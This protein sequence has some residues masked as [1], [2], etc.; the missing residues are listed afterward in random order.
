MYFY[1]LSSLSWK[2]HKQI[3]FFFHIGL[4][5]VGLKVLLPLR[6]ARAISFSWVWLSE[7]KQSV[8]AGMDVFFHGVLREQREARGETR[9]AL[10]RSS[11]KLP[12][13]VV[14]PQGHP[15]R[16]IHTSDCIT[17]TAWKLVWKLFVSPQPWAGASAAAAAA[18]LLHTQ[19]LG[20]GRPGRC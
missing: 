4:K 15:L 1:L 17:S 20:R 19:T 11:R 10:R 3:R 14:V 12:A 6:T 8:F 13:F 9:G 16:D 7:E 5:W 18:A 2:D